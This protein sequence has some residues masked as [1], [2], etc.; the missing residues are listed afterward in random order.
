MPQF[1]IVAAAAIVIGVVV[2]VIILMLLASSRL[3]EK[4]FRYPSTWIMNIILP[5]LNPCF[6][7][8]SAPIATRVHCI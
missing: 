1:N 3:C 6:E 2:V 5:A 8:V 4:H 7:K